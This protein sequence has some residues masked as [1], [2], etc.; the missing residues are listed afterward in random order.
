[1]AHKRYFYLD[2]RVDRQ[3][4]RNRLSLQWF[5]SARTAGNWLGAHHQTTV[6]VAWLVGTN[7]QFERPF[8]PG[9]QIT[10]I[11]KFRRGGKFQPAVLAVFRII[12]I[13]V[14]HRGVQGQLA[15]LGIF[16][17]ENRHGNLPLY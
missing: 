16:F 7:P 14:T 1:M 4:Y 5:L 9:I 10:H 12:T 11:G 13:S 15:D 8:F 17:I 6:P 2:V 3:V